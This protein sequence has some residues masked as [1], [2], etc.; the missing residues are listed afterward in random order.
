MVNPIV[1]LFNTEKISEELHR[2]RDSVRIF[3]PLQK[4]P[5]PTIKKQKKDQYFRLSLASAFMSVTKAFSEDGK[6]VL[7]LRLKFRLYFWAFVEIL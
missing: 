7:S 1:H 6:T 4:L 5:R 2:I 3:T